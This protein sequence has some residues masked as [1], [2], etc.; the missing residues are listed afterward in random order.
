MEEKLKRIYIPMTETGFYILFAL[1]EERHGYNII[2]YVK[3]LTGQEIIISAGTMYGSLSKMEKDGLI[4]A[5]KEENRR[6]SYLIT[7]LGEEI[8][9]HEINRIKRLYKN[10]I[11]EKIDG[12]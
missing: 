7:A 3:E 4:Q 11:G 10:S 9:V 5:T 2:Q 12:D 6:K 8:L 1:K